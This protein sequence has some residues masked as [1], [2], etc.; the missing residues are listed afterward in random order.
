M[1]K[2]TSGQLTS[3]LDG[4]T[5]YSHMALDKLKTYQFDNI[6]FITWPN[7]SPCL[8]A[9]Q[10]ILSLLERA[11][12][13][14]NL[15]LSSRGSKGG[16]LGEYASKISQLIR[17]C[18]YSKI[19]FIQLTDS[20]FTQ[21]IDS[22]R[23]EISPIYPASK[24]KTEPTIL[25]IGRRC[26][27]FLEFVGRMNN[28]P[29]FVSTGGTIRI[30][31]ESFTIQCRNGRTI[32]R[33]YVHHH[34]LSLGGRTRSV[35]PITDENIRRLSN[36]VDSAR[37]SRFIKQRRKVMLQLLEHT[38]A[39]RGEI[40]R[41]K[42]QDIIDALEMTDPMLRLETWKQGDGRIRYIPVHKMLLNDIK[43]FIDMQRRQVFK[44]LKGVQDEGFLLI[45]ETTGK[46]LVPDTIT[47]E[48]S[49]LKIVAG[50]KEKISP[51]MF[52]H[53]FITKRFVMLI[54]EHEIQNSDQFRQA[55]LDVRSFIAEV[56]MW[57]GHKSA[58]SVEHYI[59]IAFKEIAGYAKTVS[60][61]LLTTAMELFDRKQREL[62]NRLKVDLTIEEY[63]AELMELQR[64]R[65][66]DFE[67][68]RRR[69]P[70]A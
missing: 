58:E 70:A 64:L 41:I 30:T 62:L 2:D 29:E 15:G 13:G 16:S 32:K 61:V 3:L 47:S 25:A 65:D 27:N 40:S 45:G 37:S 21:F 33:N 48:I 56:M 42:V 23:K 8:P 43:K 38:G 24:K 66:E 6:P 17:F 31:H 4:L 63:E 5:L 26:L 68:A 46:G 7:G 22:L 14:G 35:F 36:A 19:D 57:T 51:H 9:N 60:S 11:G 67:I 69:A 50:I 1:S 52:R 39:R 12:R 53:A 28:N 55:L 49:T 59:H 44:K 34:S 54:K 18:S 10:Y 20:N